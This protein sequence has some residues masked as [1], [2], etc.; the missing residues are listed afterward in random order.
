MGRVGKT[1]PAGIVL[2]HLLPV[3]DGVTFALQLIVAGKPLREGC[4]FR[5]QHTVVLLYE[6][7]S[8]CPH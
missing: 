1:V 6:K 7:C 5:F 8:E 2:Q 4:Y 3:G